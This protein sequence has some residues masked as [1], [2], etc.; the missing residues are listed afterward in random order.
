[1]GRT[2]SS[3]TR[4]GQNVPATGSR[5]EFQDFEL[6][7]LAQAFGAR[8]AT[9]IPS[10]ISHDTTERD[11]RASAASSGIGCDFGF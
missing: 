9:F 5:F 11:A 3:A 10:S 8:P 6:E 7:D 4:I 1:M 2:E